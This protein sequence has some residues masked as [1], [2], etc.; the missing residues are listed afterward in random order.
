M[1]TLLQDLRYAART[2]RRNP[3][4]TAIVIL[5]LALGIGMNT[6]LF[7]VINAVLLKPLSYPDA[8][9][10]IWLSDYNPG[11]GDN[12]VMPAAYALWRDSAKS[13]ESM[14]AY[15]TQDV[16]LMFRGDASQERVA[17]HQL[18]LLGNDRGAHFAGSPVRTQRA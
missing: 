1:E 18:W 5:T 12:Y 17:F 11:W 14:V 10:L 9:R 15:G 7:S 4:F 2:L 16:A 3:G 6:A 13:F 8:S